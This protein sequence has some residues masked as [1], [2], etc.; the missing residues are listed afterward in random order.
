VIG[1]SAP[2]TTTHI[3]V[4]TGGSRGIGRAIVERLYADGSRV[5]TCGRGDRP[6]Y[7]P[8]DVLWVRADVAS[9]DDAERVVTHA[10]ERL[11]PVSL[12]VNNAGVLVAKSVADSTDE[13]WDRQIGVNCRGVFNMSRAVLPEM[14]EHGGVIV[15][16]GS[17]SG[18]VA[19][20]SSALYNASKA[21]VHALTRSIAIDHGPQV[22]CNAV[23]PGWIETDMFDEGFALAGDP[24]A[25]RRD[26]ISRHAAGRFGQPADI[27]NI[28]AWLASD[29]AAWA[30]GQCFTVDGG[31]TAASPLRP[32][33]F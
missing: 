22:R 23:L 4:V 8:E 13:D 29:E 21:F 31:L 7:L 9:P 11:G 18:V 12:L 25:A 14:N 16:I 17:I 1:H 24:A 10:R 3:A 28:V 33:A 20:L 26:A 5:A 19:D 15:N 30:T 6:A 2:V 32:E 27:A